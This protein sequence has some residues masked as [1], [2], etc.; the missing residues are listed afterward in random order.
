[1]SRSI[2]LPV[3]VIGDHSFPGPFPVID[4]ETGLVCG[5][6]DPAGS[7]DEIRL[8]FESAPPQWSRPG[9]YYSLPRG[10]NVLVCWGSGVMTAMSRCAA[11][12]HVTSMYLVPLVNSPAGCWCLACDENAAVAA[13]G[14]CADVESEDGDVYADGDS[15]DDDDA[16]PIGDIG[17]VFQSLDEGIAAMLDSARDHV[18][19]IDSF[20]ADSVRQWFAPIGEEA[21]A[22]PAPAPAADDDAAAIAAGRRAVDAILAD[23]MFAGLA[24]A[25]CAAAGVAF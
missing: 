10:C 1:M 5:N 15:P 11:V 24:F 8:V 13:V 21:S 3:G 12:F 16:E 22:P 19:W 7:S 17:G 18:P 23:P 9:H 4:P 25:F 6:Y 2:S 20:D 14:G